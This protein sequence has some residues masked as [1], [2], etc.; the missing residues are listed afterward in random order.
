M[1][2][3][4]PILQVAQ[5]IVHVKDHCYPVWIGSDLLTRIGE[6]FQMKNIPTSSVIMIISDIQVATLYLQR[7][8]QSLQQA[9]Y[10]SQCYTISAGEL[11]K[12]LSIYEKC[13]TAMLEAGCDRHSSIIALGGGVVGDLAGFVAASYMRG[14]RFI[15][16]PTTILAHDS[17]IGGKVAINHPLGKNI[18]GAF[19]QPEM[20]L[21]DTAT[22]VTLSDREVRSGLVE[23]IKHGL[24]WS[25]AFTTWC[26][27]NVAGL[28]AKDEELLTKGLLQSCAIKAEIVSFDERE[29]NLR[30]ILNFGHTIGHALE[31]SAEYK[32]LLHGEAV[33]I[34]M[35]VAA[36]LAEHLQIGQCIVQRIKALLLSYQLPITIP[37]HMDTNCIIETMMYD[38]KF[39]QGQILFVLP[40]AIGRVQVYKDV[41][42]KL[43][44]HIIDELKEERI[45]HVR[46]RDSWGDNR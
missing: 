44:R 12:S 17:S 27:E 43:V 4:H 20:V 2:Q 23:M 8:Q 40:T 24:I 36:Q 5:L 25:E 42:I 46:Q 22:L 29:D 14:I 45:D 1:R 13:I 26:E 9:G 28:L 31:V 11:S 37:A 35:V 15:Q 32:T 21:Y 38:K 16:V 34:G 10:L 7:T 30:T 3:K 41:P 19:H 18:M 33:A 6:A 39:K